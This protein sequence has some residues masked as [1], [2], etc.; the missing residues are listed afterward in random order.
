[1][2]AGVGTK[3]GSALWVED[4]GGALLVDAGCVVGDLPGVPTG[5]V[6]THAHVDHVR[7]LPEI[8]ERHPTVPVFA[9]RETANLLRSVFKG[10]VSEVRADALSDIVRAQ[11]F[12]QD[13]EV[14]PFSVELRRAGHL[15]GAAM[16]HVVGNQAGVLFSGDFSV[17]DI[18]GVASGADFEGLECDDF[19]MECS[20]APIRKLDTWRAGEAPAALSRPG[21]Y[22]AGAFGEL[23]AVLAMSPMAAHTSTGISDALDTRD[24]LRV[25]GEGGRVVV[26]GKELVARSSAWELV[27]AILETKQANVWFVNAAPRRSIGDAVLHAAPRSRIEAFGGAR[28][29]CRTGTVALPMHATRP[30]LLQMAQELPC[31]RVVLFHNHD[32]ALWG[33]AREINQTRPDV[34]VPRPGVFHTVGDPG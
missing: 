23:A 7:G 5:I 21:L 10:L 24:A 25:L 11:K 14:G 33:L 26:C 13:F 2:L 15:E 32:D 8:V 27:A 31:R 16:I 6:L 19:I 1:M 9:T 3:R 28:K 29:R 34:V 17:R 4:V 30:E 12:R 20:L 22:V 18:P